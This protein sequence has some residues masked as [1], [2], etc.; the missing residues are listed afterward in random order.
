MPHTDYFCDTE[1]IYNNEVT[2]TA[3]KRTLKT[4]LFSLLMAWCHSDV[5]MTNIQAY[6]LTQPWH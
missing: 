5:F 3:S 6:L 2:I 1:E 4:H